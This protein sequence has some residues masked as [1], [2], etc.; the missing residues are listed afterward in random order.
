M[1]IPHASYYFTNINKIILYG[2]FI[3]I[4]DFNKLNGYIGTFYDEN[5]KL[6]ILFINGLLYKETEI[7][8]NFEI[9]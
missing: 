2:I 5:N 7:S 9:N 3:T 8:E 6:L 4:N 1:L